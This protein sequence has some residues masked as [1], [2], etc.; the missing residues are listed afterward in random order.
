MASLE[1][2]I[3][4]LLFRTGRMAFAFG[5]MAPRR[6]LL[7]TGARVLPM[8][9]NVAA[10]R[11]Q[12]E[13]VPGEW[14][15]P[16]NAHQRRVLL[17]LHGG[18]YCLGSLQTHQTHVARLASRLGFRGLHIDY[19]MAP[20]HRYPAALDDTLTAY[21]WLLAQGVAPHEIVLGGESAGGG[22]VA[23]AML[24]LRDE[25]LPLPAAAFVISPWVDLTLSGGSVRTH[26]K[27]DPLLTHRHLR[28]FS[29]KYHGEHD[30]RHPLLSPIFGDFRGLPP[31][32]VQV[33]QNE[34]L[35]DDAL[36]LAERA[37]EGGVDV[38]LDVW[39]DMFHAFPVFSFL[40]ESGR[41]IQNIVR[42]VHD[43]MKP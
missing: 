19:R 5:S 43:R 34:V 2:R 15:L 28:H 29:T 39:K 22:L 35:L 1:A 24:S 7:N 21:R 17:Y 42:F 14:L 6:F 10:R 16:A 40:P 37:R 33:G 3:T 36:R 4:Q 11:V 31:I 41:A 8:P 32:L 13:G 18:G 20:E 27:A 26:G 38:E 23:A 9:R 25:G 30:P 12:V